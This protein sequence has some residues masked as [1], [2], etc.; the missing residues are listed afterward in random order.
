MQPT[1]LTWCGRPVLVRQ[2]TNGLWQAAIQA[3][4]SSPFIQG[5]IFS[6]PELAA[7]TFIHALD[8]LIHLH[9]TYHGR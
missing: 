1:T 3:G 8:E 5:G 2:L 7:D 9:A 4:P 6:L